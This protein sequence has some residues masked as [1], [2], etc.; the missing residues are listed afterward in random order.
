MN[1]GSHIKMH[2]LN[3][4]L[5]LFFACSLFSCV[6]EQKRQ[7]KTNNNY[8]P[9]PVKIRSSSPVITLIDTCQKPNII[10]LPVNS[11]RE[12][13]IQT[14]TGPQ[15]KSISS[16]EIPIQAGEFGGFSFMQNFNTEQGLSLST[17]NCSCKDKNGNLWFGTSGGGVSKYDGKS[18]TNFTSS[19][20]LAN[21]IVKCIIEDHIGNMWFG[22]IGGGISKYDGKKLP[23]LQ[24]MMGLHTIEF[25]L[26]LK[27]GKEIFGVLP[28]MELVNMIP[29]L[30]R[31]VLLNLLQIIQ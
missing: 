4:S 24:L 19:Q 12:C 9:A 15:V 6:Q 3:Y 11:K 29:I 20:G 28:T 23:H 10:H 17:I 2:L 31:M 16:S 14:A 7:K 22:T 30:N 27:T 26:L 18:F 21:N 5:P 8:L 1:P 13:T 25:P